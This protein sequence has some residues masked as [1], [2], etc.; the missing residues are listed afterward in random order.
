MKTGAPTLVL[1]TM[2]CYLLTILVLWLRLM[3]LRVKGRQRREVKLAT[4]YKEK[5]NKG[6]ETSR[7]K[8]QINLM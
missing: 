6:F 3:V 2:Q 4:I 5:R 7:I 8:K 1:E